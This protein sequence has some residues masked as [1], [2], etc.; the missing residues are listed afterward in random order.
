MP[1]LS[2]KSCPYMHGSVSG[3]SIPFPWIYMSIFVPIWHC[4]NYISIT[5]NLNI[6]YKIFQLY[7]LCYCV[8]TYLLFISYLLLAIL[9]RLLFHINFRISLL[10]STRKI[11][12]E[13]WMELHWICKSFWGRINIFYNINLLICEYNVSLG[14]FY[15]FS[16][17]YSFLERDLA[18]LLLDLFLGLTFL[19]DIV[20]NILKFFS[21]AHFFY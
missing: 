13:Y 7:L 20:N 3:F 12:L 5:V 14:H 11:P 1:S 8:V 18:Y 19:G 10:I 16:I 2:H 9:D 4:L 15:F 21:F 6:C 17:F